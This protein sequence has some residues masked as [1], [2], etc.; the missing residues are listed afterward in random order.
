MRSG[1]LR[2]VAIQASINRMWFSS[3]TS[4]GARF[5]KYFNPISVEMLALV[6]TVVSDILT[7][8]QVT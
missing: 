6:L 7:S 4:E 5:P 1:L 3:S 2:N 8:A